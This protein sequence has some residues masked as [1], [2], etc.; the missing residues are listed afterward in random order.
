MAAIYEPIFESDDDGKAKAG[1]TE[2]LNVVKLTIVLSLKS[3][4][5]KIVMLLSISC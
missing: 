5:S 2:F 1:K 3:Y 4:I